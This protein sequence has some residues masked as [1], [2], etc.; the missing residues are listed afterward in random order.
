MILWGGEMIDGN[1]GD[2]RHKVWGKGKCGRRGSI[3]D[4]VSIEKSCS[5]VGKT[6]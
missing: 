6:N 3:Q 5:N 4:A 2:M 1:G